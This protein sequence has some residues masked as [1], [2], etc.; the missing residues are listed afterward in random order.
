[1]RAVRWTTKTTGRCAVVEETGRRRPIVDRLGDRG[2]AQEFG[3]L[4]AHPT[5]RVLPNASRR[6]SPAV[7]LDVEEHVDAFDGL[8]R[9]RREPLTSPVYRR[10]DSGQRVAVF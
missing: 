4:G 2:V 9:D 6:T 3:A 7:A 5:P 8:E 1:M 10:L